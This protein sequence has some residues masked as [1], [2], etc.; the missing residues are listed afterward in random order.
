MTL[1]RKVIYIIYYSFMYKSKFLDCKCFLQHRKRENR[2]REVPQARLLS[3][4]AVTANTHCQLNVSWHD[5]D[6]L[7]VNGAQI[8]VFE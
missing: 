4:S 8:C 6:A 2:M 1:V 7:S 3:I 5:G